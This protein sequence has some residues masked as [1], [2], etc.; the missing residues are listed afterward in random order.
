MVKNINMCEILLSN[1]QSI[2]STHITLFC[3]TDSQSGKLLSCIYPEVVPHET[4]AQHHIL[5]FLYF[6][7]RC[8]NVFACVED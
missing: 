6:I 2:P 7:G 4:V 1:Y 8:L 5:M 3:L